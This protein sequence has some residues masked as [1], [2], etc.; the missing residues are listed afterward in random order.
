[1]ELGLSG[2]RMVQRELQSSPIVVSP[3]LF[4]P[5]PESGSNCRKFLDCNSWA[6]AES[7]G[8]ILSD[9][10]AG[11]SKFNRLATDIG[12]PKS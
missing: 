11:S 8:N 4:H 7:L 3:D 5:L 2:T 10:F 1:M 12:N 9:S 6:I